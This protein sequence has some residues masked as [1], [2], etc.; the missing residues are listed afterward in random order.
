ME[1]IT[2]SQEELQNL[3]QKQIDAALNKLAQA[4]KYQRDYCGE[5]LQYLATGPK[6]IAELKKHISTS[7]NRIYEALRLLQASN[8]IN[9]TRVK[10]KAIYSLSK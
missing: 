3:I 5:I 4:P 6:G 8:K 2:L 9:V 7:E 1:M 10:T